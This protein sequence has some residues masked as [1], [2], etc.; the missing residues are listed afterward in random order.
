MKSQPTG[1]PNIFPAML[2]A[3]PHE[4]YIL[5][6]RL[7]IPWVNGRALDRRGAGR[8]FKK[9]RAVC[10]REIFDRRKRCDDC[11]AVRTLR[12]GK[13]RERGNRKLDR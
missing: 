11:P 9:R 4:L 5:N 7:Y 6:E 3:L 1:N 12:I 13:N 10:H 8:A 2:D